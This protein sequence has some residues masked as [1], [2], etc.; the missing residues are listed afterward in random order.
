MGLRNHKTLVDK[1]TQILQ[2]QNGTIRTP[3]INPPLPAECLQERSIVRGSAELHR[4][5]V[6]E[7]APILRRLAA[8]GR[9]VV[10]LEEAA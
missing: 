10:G 9:E 8:Q 4:A 5:I 6:R 7:H 2:P 1:I 3:V